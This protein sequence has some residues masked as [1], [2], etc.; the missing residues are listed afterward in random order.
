MIYVTHDQTEAMTLADKIVVLRDGMVEQVGS[1]MDLYNDPTNQFVA[2]FLGSP[3]M[4]FFKK[5][6]SGADPDIIIGIRPE[7]LRIVESGRISGKITHVER[8]GGDTN[9]LIK[10]DRDETL[11]VRLFGQD[12]SSVGDSIALDFD[13][14][15]AFQFDAAGMRL[16]S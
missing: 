3:S 15:H 16:R 7:H 13:D 5:S 14:A 6:I 9:L 1:P 2:G 11:T 4:N 10:T 12:D 8:L